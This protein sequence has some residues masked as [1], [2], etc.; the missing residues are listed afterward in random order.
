MKLFLQGVLGAALFL[1][2]LFTLFYI[3]IL[4]VSGIILMGG[5]IPL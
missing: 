4:T 3:S 1:L 2:A 5:H